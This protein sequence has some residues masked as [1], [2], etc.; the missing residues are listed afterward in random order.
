M[1]DDAD[2]AIVRS[3]LRKTQAVV[4]QLVTAAMKDPYALTTK[5][6]ADRIRFI[7]TYTT[8]AIRYMMEGPKS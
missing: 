2:A 1:I 6:A 4:S 8:V 3:L 5:E 7:D